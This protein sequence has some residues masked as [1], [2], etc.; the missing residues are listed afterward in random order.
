VRKKEGLK[1]QEGGDV[2]LVQ[3]Q[4]VPIGLSGE[5]LQ[6]EIDAVNNPPEPATLEVIEDEVVNDVPPE[7]AKMMLKGY[8][9]EV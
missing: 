7:A 4:M 6:A 8:A 2:L 3:M 5:K 9:N 1:P